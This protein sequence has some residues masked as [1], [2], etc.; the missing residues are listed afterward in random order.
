MVCGWASVGRLLLV[1]LRGRQVLGRD[2]R[3]RQQGDAREQA[4]ADR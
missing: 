3:E 4:A 1:R 2:E